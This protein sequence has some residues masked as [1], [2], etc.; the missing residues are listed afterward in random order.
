MTRLLAL[1]LGLAV[2]VPTSFAGDC[3][4]PAPTCCEPAPVCCEPA[5]VCC[6][7][8]PVKMV[9]CV[10]DPC[11]G[12]VYPET[13][14]IPACCEGETPCM[15]WRKGIFGRKVLTYKWKCCG[16]CVEVVITKHGRT[17]VRG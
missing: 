3:C 9:L 8:P 2:L 6:P 13:I 4:E 15:T 10:T 7:P 5:P 16:H 14:C 12:C 11:T 1:A 17:I